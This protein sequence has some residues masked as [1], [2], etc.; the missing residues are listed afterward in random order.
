MK[1]LLFTS[2]EKARLFALSSAAMLKPLPLLVAQITDLHL[3][4]A[5]D[6]QLLDLPTNDCL[7]AVLEQL[8]KQQPK[9]DILLLT[10][11]LSQRWKS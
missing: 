2:I 4:A 10:G 5:I 6:C 3:F 9:P 8:A 1:Q 7:Q 11:D